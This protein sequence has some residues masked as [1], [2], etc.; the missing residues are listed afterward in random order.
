MPDVDYEMC[1]KYDNVLIS[2]AAA[3][4]GTVGEKYADND[5]YF[6]IE[7]DDNEHVMY[8]Q[9]RSGGTPAGHLEMVGTLA[10]FYS[11]YAEGSLIGEGES[12]RLVF[13]GDVVYRRT[14]AALIVDNSD[15]WQ[16][17]DWDIV[18]IHENDPHI[19]HDQV[20]EWWLEHVAL[21]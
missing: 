19:A 8:D 2:V 18:N 12:L 13:D 16:Q 20:I 4:G 7:F 9:C 6:K 21:L 14:E 15:A 17:I 10:G 3:G 5:W 1:V 11:A